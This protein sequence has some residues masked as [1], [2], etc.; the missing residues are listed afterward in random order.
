VKSV[1]LIISMHLMPVIVK[2][3]ILSLF[4]AFEYCTKRES[5]Q[6]N[7]TSSIQIKYK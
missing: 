1:F 6:E 4:E 7:N 3:Q 5:Y 2:E